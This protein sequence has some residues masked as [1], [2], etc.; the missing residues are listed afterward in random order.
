[1]KSQRSSFIFFAA[2]MLIATLS[3][4]GHSAGIS[5]QQSMQLGMDQSQSTRRETA[6]PLPASSGTPGPVS[7]TS[8]I[9]GAT[10]TPIQLEEGL[11]LGKDVFPDGNTQTG[12][13]GDSV[14][15]I[16]CLAN[17]DFEH[18]P[19]SHLSLLIN[20]ER[21]AVP[22]AVGIVKYG[23]ESHGIT[24]SGKCFYY[25][26]THDADGVIHVEG[27]L[28]QT[29]TLGQFFDIWG[30]T[31]TSENV[32]G[33]SGVVVAYVAVTPLRHL[34]ASDYKLWTGDVRSIP[35]GHHTAIML[36]VGPTFLTPPQIPAV[37]FS[38]EY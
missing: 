12:G 3:A 9:P 29:F 21:L 28:T 14:D 15:G 24:N 26:H 36:E 11:V 19:H 22:D 18:H 5:P 37:K 20:G 1:M 7:S 6:T 17:M 30:Q 27:P 23:A 34:V 32:A 16:P 10:P 33:Y 31:L 2:A 25:L 38:V 4:C 35:F 13:Q 8:P